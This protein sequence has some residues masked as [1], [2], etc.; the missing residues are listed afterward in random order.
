MLDWNILSNEHDGLPEEERRK[1]MGTRIVGGWTGG[2]VVWEHWHWG[3]RWLRVG[4]LTVCLGGQCWTILESGW[5]RRG[6]HLLNVASPIS[7][8][9]WQRDP[10][11]YCIDGENVAFFYDVCFLFPSLITI[12]VIFYCLCLRFEWERTTK[13]Y[14]KQK[15][16]DGVCIS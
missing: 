4:S 8:V 10:T 11:L 9:S 3:R 13:M 2:G 15:I 12:Y 14:M 16:G 1:W 7:H 5:W 6:K